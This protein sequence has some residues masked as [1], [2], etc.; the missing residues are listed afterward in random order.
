MFLDRL[1]SF[2]FLDKNIFAI[3]SFDQ[4]KIWDG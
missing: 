1:C 2:R 4:Q 3:A